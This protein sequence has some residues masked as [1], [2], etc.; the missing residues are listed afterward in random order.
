VS[1]TFDLFFLFVFLVGGGSAGGIIAA[2]LSEQFSVLLLEAGGEMSDWQQIPAM[3]LLMLSYPEI[4]WNFKTVSQKKSC[5]ALPRNRSHWSQGKGLGGTANLNFLI[6]S[7]GA[8]KDF[9][10]WAEYLNDSSWSYESV[11]PYFKKTE[12]YE[13]RWEDSNFKLKN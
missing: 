13:G 4:D 12:N 5:F 6:Q 2:R 11:L 9:D 10:R 7:R 3:T 8:P 1:L